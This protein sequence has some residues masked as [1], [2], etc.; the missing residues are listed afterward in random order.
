MTQ[1]RDRSF[2]V[3]GEVCVDPDGPMQADWL[4]RPQARIEIWAEFLV[5]LYPK[6]LASEDYDLKPNLDTM[7]ERYGAWASARSR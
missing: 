3:Y 2:D 6:F 5:K 4:E 7:H 1:T